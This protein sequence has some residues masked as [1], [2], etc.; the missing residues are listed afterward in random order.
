MSSLLLLAFRLHTLAM[1]V[2]I[3]GFDVQFLLWDHSSISSNSGEWL[4]VL[5]YDFD[6]KDYTL[7][8]FNLH[9]SMHPFTKLLV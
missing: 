2:G 4:H 9:H 6:S 8:T 3:A 5:S 7:S 1:M